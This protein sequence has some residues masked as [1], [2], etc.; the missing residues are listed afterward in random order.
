MFLTI[1]TRCCRRPQQLI[2]N[3]DSLRRQTSDEWEQLFL[4]DHTG[5]HK[6]DPIV[7]ANAQF[8]RYQHLP[9]GDYVYSRWCISAQRK[10]D[11]RA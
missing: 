2:R 1:I 9:E 11:G 6:G 10:Q 8:E 3:I 4:V 7:W 5:R